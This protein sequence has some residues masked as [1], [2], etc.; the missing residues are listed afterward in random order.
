MNY[1][2]SNTYLS[3]QEIG[4]CF[5]ASQETFSIIFFLL[6]FLILSNVICLYVG[7]YDM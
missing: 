4:H 5:N 7:F 1:L 6:F 2:F 3:E